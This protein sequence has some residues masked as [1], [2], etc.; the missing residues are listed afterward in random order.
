M[1]AMGSRV[2][3]CSKGLLTKIKESYNRLLCTKTGL[4]ST[5]FTIKFLGLYLYDDYDGLYQIIKD[6][7]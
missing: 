4:D 7:G 2:W 3:G 5:R 1:W 6:G